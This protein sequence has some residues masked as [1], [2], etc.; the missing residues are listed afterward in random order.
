MFRLDI[1]AKSTLP[2]KRQIIWIISSVK[3][4]W[5]QCLF[6]KRTLF[7]CFA[8][9]CASHAPVLVLPGEG[10]LELLSLASISL[11][12]QKPIRIEWLVFISFRSFLVGI[13]N[14]Y[15]YQS[16]TCNSNFN[17]GMDR[18]KQGMFKSM[19]TVTSSWK[20][21]NMN[22]IKRFQFQLFI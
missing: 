1:R 2:S 4:K 14:A 10:F 19:F 7:T 9:F 18:K 3:F 15:A 16:C 17:E 22:A 12:T 13:T 21:S 8:H 20:V 5:A 11:A 6:K